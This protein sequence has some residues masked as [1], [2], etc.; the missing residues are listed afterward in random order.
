WLKRLE[1]P[2]K[3][4]SKDP[5]LSYSEEVEDLGGRF[6]AE[7]SASGIELPCEWKEW[8][9]WSGSGKR[10]DL[11]MVWAC[12]YLRAKAEN[13]VYPA[14]RLSWNGTQGVDPTFQGYIASVPIWDTNLPWMDGFG[15]SLSWNAKKSLEVVGYPAVSSKSSSIELSS[16]T[17]IEIIPQFEAF[18]GRNADAWEE[19]IEHTM[20]E[21]LAATGGLYTSF[22]LIFTLIFG[23]S[24]I[25]LL[26]GGR[27]ISPFGAIAFAG[28]R[29]LQRKLLRRYP[30]LEADDASERG[31]A[32]SDFLCDFVV[33]MGPVQPT[34]SG[35]GEATNAAPEL[36]SQLTGPDDADGTT[37]PS[38]PASSEEEIKKDSTTDPSNLA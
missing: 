6:N 4:Y 22:D 38:S 2:P 34:R 19:Y 29:S 33:D 27:P 20:V 26:F 11:G 21:G 12:Y 9:K 17:T 24:L 3:S 28:R 16:Q 30:G 10:V 31:R 14:I 25:G 18:Y 35:R 1:S 32:V 7:T 37:E 23:R 13:S 36:Q 5:W 15:S 8:W